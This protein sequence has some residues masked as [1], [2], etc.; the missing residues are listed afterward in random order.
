MRVRSLHPRDI[1]KV[2]EPMESMPLQLGNRRCS[3]PGKR[4]AQLQH[5]RRVS[6]ALSRVSPEAWEEGRAGEGRAPLEAIKAVGLG[7]Q[8]PPNCS[9]ERSQFFELMLTCD[10]SWGALRPW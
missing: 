3:D 6:A 7:L 5:P 8:H 10:A 9:P 4:D 2:G 1:R